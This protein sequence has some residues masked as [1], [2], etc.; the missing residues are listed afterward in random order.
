IVTEFN[1]YYAIISIIFGVFSTTFAAWSSV[2]KDL[3]ETP[4][5]LM[6]PK[7]QKSG[8]RILLER[9][10]PI[11][12]R[13]NFTQK[14]TVRNLIRYKKR[15]FMTILGVGGCTA[16]MVAGFG[17]KDSILETPKK[18]YDEI[19]QYDMVV[20][21]KDEGLKDARKLVEKNKGISEYLLI[22]EENIKLGVKEEKDAS[23]IVPKDFNRMENFI[24]LRDRVTGE[25]IPLRDDGIILT[26]KMSNLLGVNL[27]DELYI[28]DEG[29]EKVK[30]KITGITENYVAHYIYMTPKLYEKLYDEEVGFQKL[31][32]KNVDTSDKFEEELSTELLKNS[33]VVSVDF[34]TGISS[35]YEDM[36]G[37]LDYVVLVLIISAGALA[38][39]VL[40]N[41]TN[42]NISERMREIATIKVLGFYDNEVSAYVYNENTV[43]TIIGIILGLIMG[44]F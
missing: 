25:K 36:V 44:Y 11:L 41:L 4:A 39:V 23:L 31:L 22:K 24:V 21:L 33:E 3:V 30:V 1:I 35:S 37:S 17:L 13:L 28:K 16:L 18:Q 15:L 32:T 7:A 9:I 2:Y 26:E 6:R 43:L 42:V 20:D 38:F 8:K 10:K 29:N 19:Y 12:Y 5:L 34:I 27:G 14:V 40:Y